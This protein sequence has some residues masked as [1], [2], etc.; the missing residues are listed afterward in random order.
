M[1]GEG[2]H[3]AL[4]SSACRAKPP[5]LLH[6]GR[7]ITPQSLRRA[8]QYVDLLAN[9]PSPP[10]PFGV[11]LEEAARLRSRAAA[12][13]SHNTARCAENGEGASSGSAVLG[14]ED[15]EVPSLLDLLRKE[16]GY[17]TGT[18]MHRIWVRQP[19]EYLAGMA[20]RIAD[21]VLTRV[22]P[23]VAGVRKGGESSHSQ[24]EANNTSRKPQFVKQERGN[25]DIHVRFLPSSAS[26]LQV[27]APIAKVF[28]A[29]ITVRDAEALRRLEE[30]AELLRAQYTSVAA[31]GQTVQSALAF[32][33]AI[34]M[35]AAAE[36]NE[37]PSADGASTAVVLGR[38]RNPAD[39]KR[40][41]RLSVGGA[42]ALWM[43]PPN[44]RPR[45]AAGSDTAAAGINSSIR[46]KLA[47]A[48]Q[49]TGLEP[50]RFP[51]QSTAG[52]VAVFYL[53]FSGTLY[54]GVLCGAAEEGDPYPVPVPH[55]TDAA[56]DGSMTGKRVET[57]A[58]PL[59][60]EP[61]FFLPC[62]S[63]NSFVRGLLGL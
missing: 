4:A 12:A 28:C 41:R 2:S 21:V 27:H 53:A 26:S 14:A 32:W 5:L 62:A 46:R 45:L 40:A 6:L 19:Q 22:M 48:P 59:D 1:Q 57:T 38:A 47:A 10:H 17:S 25:Y 55:R 7:V 3:A 36:E 30:D 60:V 61:V 49:T 18:A 52:L 11:F 16:H 31:E 8:R 13:A 58:T 24:S 43:Q 63:S 23:L 29:E 39:E 15:A 51:L 54:T 44:K 37:G 20:Q 33:R 34:Q 9:P 42:A 35:D 56:S 50:P